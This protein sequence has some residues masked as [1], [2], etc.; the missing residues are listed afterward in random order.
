MP[1]RHQ[2]KDSRSP[3]TKGVV[4]PTQR[5]RMDSLVAAHM[6]GV[7]GTAKEVGGPRLMDGIQ[8]DGEEA[9]ELQP[10]GPR[11]GAGTTLG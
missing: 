3:S 7:I 9:W 8:E 4:F 1:D 10:H 5:G 11:I 2:E 6:E